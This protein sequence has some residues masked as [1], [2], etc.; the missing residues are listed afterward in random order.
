MSKPIHH[1]IN[2]ANK[3]GGEFTDYEP[4][5]T[6]MD[7]SKASFPKM[8]HRIVFHHDYG[9][10]L[11]DDIFAARWVRGEF[12]LL[13]TE[14]H[15]ALELI[16]AVAEQHVT[17]DLGFVPTLADW[18]KDLLVGDGRGASLRDAWLGASDLPILS[19]AF[20]GARASMAGLFPITRRF[21]KKCW[22]CPTG[23]PVA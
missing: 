4:I 9:V 13:S 19:I 6:M 10:K 21:T 16:P 8:A 1:A 22:R 23:Q 5:H 7:R 11:I 3:F 14:S 15:H 2:S 20:V 12:P 18:D 17:E